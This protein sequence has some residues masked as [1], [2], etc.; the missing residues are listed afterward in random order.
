M[1]SRGDL[2]KIRQIIKEELTIK[3]VTIERTNRVTGAKEVKTIDLYIPEWIAA[4]L[5]ELSAAL[6]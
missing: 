1:L 6:R 4:E 2:Y 5:P 3:D